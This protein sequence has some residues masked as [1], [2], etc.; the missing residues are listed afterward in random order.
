MRVINIHL[1]EYNKLHLLE[2]DYLDADWSSAS[3]ARFDWSS[4]LS[5]SFWMLF[6]KKFFFSLNG[7]ISW[8]LLDADWS[9]KAADLIGRALLSDS[10]FSV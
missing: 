1:E 7:A 10:P 8:H 2:I 9:I 6:E 4:S 5:V 3:P